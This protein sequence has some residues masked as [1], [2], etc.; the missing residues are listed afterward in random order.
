MKILFSDVNDS[1]DTWTV[2]AKVLRKWVERRKA[3][4]Y[5]VW[6]IG[7]ILVD[8][9][10]D[11]NLYYDIIG[12]EN[13]ININLWG[14]C[15][16]ETYAKKHEDMEPPII[17]FV[18][19]ARLNRNTEYGH[20]SNAFNATL[21]TLNPK[22]TEANLLKERLS[23]EYSV[24]SQLFTQI[25]S[26]DHPTY[27]V[28]SLLTFRTRIPLCE[29]AKIDQECDVVTK[30]TIQ[31]V[32]ILYGWSY[33]ACPCDKK[34]EY[35]SN[36]TLRCSKCDKDVLTIV[37]KYKIHYKVYNDTTKCSIIFFDRHATELLGK[38]TSKI[39]EDM[40]EEGRNTN[41][42]EELDKV[43]RKV[44]IVKLRIKSHNIKHRTSSIGVTQFCADTHLIEKFQ[45][46]NVEVQTGNVIELITPLD[47]NTKRKILTGDIL[48]V[49]EDLGLSELSTPKL[50]SIK[51]VKNIKKEKF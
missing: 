17:V 16:E 18:C 10:V 43:A 44:V 35:Q 22:I 13:L 20:L 49:C 36:G 5:T 45:Y 4:P 39:K 26:V 41:V 40:Q 38:S 1:K 12:C 30:V 37:P 28:E 32:E 8:E 14:D 27:S 3:A 11:V 23:Q 24:G 31:K 19:F 33:D 50:S 21:V 46:S 25:S 48:N 34:H 2:H 47:S 15:A 6:K 7:M 51:P 42:P 29:I 9:E